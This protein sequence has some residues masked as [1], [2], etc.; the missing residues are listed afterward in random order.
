MHA[1]FNEEDTIMTKSAAKHLGTCIIK[2]NVQATSKRCQF[3]DYAMS[4]CCGVQ[5]H[6]LIKDAM[7]LEEINKRLIHK[8]MTIVRMKGL[9]LSMKLCDNHLVRLSNNM[10]NIT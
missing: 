10:D 5:A 3:I 6:C 9:N 4:F 8:L 7:S 2:H 1:L